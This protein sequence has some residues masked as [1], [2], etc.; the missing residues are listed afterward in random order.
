MLN[1]RAAARVI[2]REYESAFAPLGVTASQFSILVALDAKPA[3]PMSELAQLL[4]MD[5]TTLTRVLG[6]MKR[7]GW[8]LS[9]ADT[10]DGRASLI[11]LSDQGKAKLPE[12]I[13]AWNTVQTRMMTKL[14]PKAGPL[15]SQ[16][17]SLLQTT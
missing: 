17:Q 7:D 14:G 9:R 3:W 4:S 5:R 1:L 12:L 13:A 8:V 16:L 2:T 6:P 15:L 11:S 10:S